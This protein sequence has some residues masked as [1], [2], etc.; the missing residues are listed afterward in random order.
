M[1]LQL[2]AHYVT[3]IIYFFSFALLIFLIILI[4]RKRD[5]VIAK[6]DLLKSETDFFTEKEN[7][8]DHLVRKNRLLNDDLFQEKL[9]I[10]AEAQFAFSNISFFNPTQEVAFLI[11]SFSKK[12]SIQQKALKIFINSNPVA[13]DERQ[14]VK[15]VD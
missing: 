10:F 14:V 13:I 5:L 3:G 2:G 11:F 4:K 7:I 8:S 12:D 9:S 15:S 6:K 1:D